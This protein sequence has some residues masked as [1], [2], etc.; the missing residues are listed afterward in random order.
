[1]IRS[2]SRIARRVCWDGPN[3]SPGEFLAG[4]QSKLVWLI[5]AVQVHRRLDAAGAGITLELARQDAPLPNGAVLHPAI[6]VQASD[7]SG[8]A[9]TRQLIGS[10]PTAVM[11]DSWRDPSDMT[12]NASKRPR[13]IAGY[14]TYC[15][16][17]RMMAGRGSQI[18]SAHIMAA[19]R[20]RTQVDLAVIGCGGARDGE[21]NAQAYGPRLGPS[22][23]AVLQATS[24]GEVKAAL[25]RF[26]ATH[27]PMLIEI[28]LRN[29]SLHAWCANLATKLGK[30]P[31]L[32]V[33]MGRLLTILDILADHYE[34]DIKADLAIGAIL[35]PA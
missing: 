24:S 30:P 25:D 35:E 12:P 1:M 29:R 17:R 8:P 20:F 13:E 26:A 14:R 18:T 7:P 33:E 6:R 2:K 11:K 15:P 27:H 32:H 28:V 16:L 19:D 4:R 3:P 9:R 22:A 10:G 23:A 34:T 5:Q 31:D 21:P